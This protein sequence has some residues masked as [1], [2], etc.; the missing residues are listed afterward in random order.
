MYCNNPLELNNFNTFY[1][2]TL[3]SKDLA[4][5]EF[6]AFGQFTWA[7]SPLLNLTLSA[8]WFPDLEGYFAGP[9]L[10]YSLGGKSRFFSSLAAFQRNNGGGKNTN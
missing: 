7:I 5:S 10:D 4:F 8:M 3:S 2:G 9:S 1:S 6:S